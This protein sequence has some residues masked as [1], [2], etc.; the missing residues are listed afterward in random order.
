MENIKYSYHFSLHL[1][2]LNDIDVDK[3][4]NYFK[5]EAYKKTFLK[6][7]KGSCKTAKL[8]Y[9]SKDYTDVNTDIVIEKF[10]EKYFNNFRDL[11]NI[12][13]KNNGKATFTLYFTEVKERP[14]ISLTQKTIDL[15]NKL[16]ILFDV[17]FKR[18]PI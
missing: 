6:D 11:K 10:I 2:F 14:I 3:L 4:E 1:Q 7:S 5:I 9:K 8:W 17:D 15:F 18:F 16:G 13:E 12:L